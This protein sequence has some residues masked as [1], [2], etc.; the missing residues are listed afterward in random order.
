[1]NL[2]LNSKCRKTDYRVIPRRGIRAKVYDV[3]VNKGE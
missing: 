2:N 1:M 3:V